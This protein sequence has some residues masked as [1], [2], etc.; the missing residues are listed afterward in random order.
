MNKPTRSV[1]MFSACAIAIMATCFSGCKK[2]GAGAGM[3]MPPPAVT[4]ANPVKQ[5]V[6]IYLKY[7][8]QVRAK[9]IVDIEARVRGYLE[10]VDFKDGAKINKGDKLFTIE[11]VEMTAAVEKA[12]A[13]IAKANA[14]VT[15]T[16]S[17]LERMQN[18]FKTKAVSEIDVLVAQGNL[19]SA[20]ANLMAA[21]AQLASAELDLSYTIITAPITGRISR[22]LVSVGNLVGAGAPTKLAELVTIDPID[23]YFNIDERTLLGFLKTATGVR[24][25][26]KEG[27]YAVKLELANGELYKA[28][29]DVDYVGNQV[30]VGTGTLPIRAKFSNDKGK[31]ISGM[32][33]KV[34]IPQEYK[35]AILV[36][37]SAIQRDMVGSFLLAVNDKGVVES[38]YVKVGPIYEG[39]RIITEGISVA[40]RIIVNGLSRARPGVTVNAQEA[41]ASAANPVAENSDTATPAEEE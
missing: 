16:K 14:E 17:S 34:L 23:V 13:D 18:A 24:D 35:D 3:Q 30:D 40:D 1:V 36:P 20:K 2:K 6:T 26:V 27:S 15:V 28:D 19:D 9:E 8:G 12:K 29:G 25:A 10:S 5:D 38:R 41:K 11:S 7:P 4:V 33:A 37:M 22:H 39:E 31:L 21:K 32:F